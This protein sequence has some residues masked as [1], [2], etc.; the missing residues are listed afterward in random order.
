MTAMIDTDPASVT[1]LSAREMGRLRMR[2]VLS[3]IIGNFFELFDFAIYGFF[4]AAIGHTFFPSDDPV[5]SVLKSFATYGVGFI[6]RPIGAVVIGAYGDRKGRKAALVATILLM[7]VATGATGLIPSYESIGIWAPVLL[8]LC[9]LLQGF[10]TGGEWGG[11][12]SFLVEY[13]PPGRRGFF[14]SWQQFS[15]GVG[16]LAGSAAASAI[17][18]LLAPD[19]VNAWGWRIPFIAGMLIAPV[20]YYLRSKVSETPAFIRA[21]ETATL[22][23]SPLRATFTTHR[24]AVLSGFGLTIVWTV[25]SYLFLTFM[26]TFAVQQLHLAPTT[27]LLSNSLAIV[28]LAVLT[29][30]MGTLSDRIGRKPMMLAAAAIYL[31]AGYPLFVQITTEGSFASLLTVQV[32]AA[33]TL[34]LFSGPAPALLCELYPTNIRYTSL[35][36]GYNVAVMLF[37]GFAPFIATLLIQQTGSPIAPTFYLMAAAL[38]S[39]V[40]ISTVTD[41]YRERL[42]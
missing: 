1:S 42:A 41:K 21:V 38:V 31:V 39:I 2:A 40:A 6:M 27:A 18:Y 14:G 8:V 24:R 36:I 35:S 20:G 17:S 30:L 5:I 25:S 34:A 32:I 13:A 28:V 7:A 29:P 3:C 23:A 22:S 11:A 9:R 16:L 10:S 26:P 19:A 37:G 4:A 15:V 12:T 33:A